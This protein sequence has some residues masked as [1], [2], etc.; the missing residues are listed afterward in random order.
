MKKYDVVVFGGGTAGVIAA[1]QAARAG[2]STLLVEKNGML[3]GTITMAGISAPGHF[4]AWGKQVISGIGWELARRTIEMEGRPVPTP[5]YTRDNDKPH[6]VPMD[7]VLYAIVCDEAILKAGVEPLYHAMPA[8]IAWRDGWKIRLCTKTGLR[9]IEAKVVIDATGDANAV[10]MAG[11][12][13][14]RPAIQQPATLSMR[15]SGYDLEKLD[16]PA[17]KAAADAAIAAGELKSTDLSWRNT[18]PESFLRSRGGNANHLHAEGADTSEG[19]T[20]AEIEGRQTMARMYRFFKKQPGLEQFRI[21]WVC[22]EVGI[23]ET[24]TIKGKATMTVA[25]YE[26]GR[27]YPDAVCYAYYNIDEHLND[28]AGINYRRLKPTVV[29]TI[30][31]GALLPAGSRFLL[32]A[33][34]CVASDRETNSAVRVEC[35]CMAMGQAAG[36]MAALSARTGVDPEALPLA[37]IRTLLEKHGAIVPA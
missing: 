22:P 18:G 17:L 16:I 2:A 23:R 7:K 20:A 8:E 4:F 24:C 31:R 33:G 25:D 9:A 30:P 3:G 1:I 12:E 28:G 36:V 15:I 21:E 27:V 29:P 34:R 26:S 37:D 14:V 11:F 5:D 10:A 32:V 6:H 35:P 13:V 19:R